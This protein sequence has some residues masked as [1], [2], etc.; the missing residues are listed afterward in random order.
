MPY[1]INGKPIEDEGEDDSMLLKGVA[2][3]IAAILLIAALCNIADKLM[4]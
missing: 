4:L 1:D 2:M 3:A